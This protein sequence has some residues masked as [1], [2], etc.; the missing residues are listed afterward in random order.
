MKANFQIRSFRSWISAATF[1]HPEV[2]FRNPTS[3]TRISTSNFQL[4]RVGSWELENQLPIAD[5]RKLV[6][7]FQL[8]TVRHFDF[9]AKTTTGTCWK[10]QR[11]RLQTSLVEGAGPHRSSRVPT[12]FYGRFFQEVS[13]LENRR[14]F[15]VFRHVFAQKKY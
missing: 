14:F 4:L 10:Q 11:N 15:H 2:G 3:G 1:Q 6:S 9:A 7:N 12:G 13:P 8:L 5:H